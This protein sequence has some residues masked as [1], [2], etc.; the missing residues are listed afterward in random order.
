MGSMS[1]SRR[2]FLRTGA[3]FAAAPLAARAKEPRRPNILFIIAD[4]MGY[5][6]L[7]CYGGE[8]DTPH[9]DRLA[10]R[11][12]RF[13]QF[14]NYGK[15]EPTRTALMTGH[16]NTPEI[17]CYG[18]RAESF[19]PALLR[20]QGYRTLMAGKWHVSRNPTDRGF[21]RFFGIE[22]GACNYY[23]GSGR[24]KL[25][26]TKFPVPAE[27]FY[28]TDAFT[29]YAIRFLDEAQHETPE[30]PFFMYLAYNA[31]HDPLQVPEEDIGKYR[32][33]YRAGWEY[34]KQRRFERIKQMGLIPEDAAMTAWPEN[35][36]HWDELTDG[37]KD[38]EDC[39][40]ATYAAMI[41]RMD[42]QIGRVL[43]WLEKNRKLEN[44]LIVFISD[45]GANPFDRGSRR[46]VEAGILPGGPDSHWSL[47][48]AWAHVSNTPFR[49]YKRN[50]HEGGIC[51]PMILHWPEAGYEAGSL[52]RMPVHVLD[53][54][55]TFHALAGGTAR[56][57]GIEGQDISAA[58][59][60]GKQS[61]PDYR[62]MAYMVDHRYVRRGDW[63]LVSVDGEPWELH[64]LGRD[65]TE[66]V[67]VVDEHPEIARAFDRAFN[68]W[69]ESFRKEPFEKGKGTS[70]PLRMGDRGTGAQYVPVEMP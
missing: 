11:G 27:G 21:E 20:E 44:T 39:R 50:M 60:A 16:R 31:P 57:P 35:L 8:V 54:L 13:T 7:G 53:F 5:S 66:T 56:P 22:E 41:D 32:G 62:T 19:L 23:T 29:D 61:R 55:P 3:A 2:D 30:Q 18:E 1:F 51:G 25:G 33:V 67:N 48:T 40:M 64:H 28:T 59:R 45:N 58:L 14:Y 52:A 43:R 42:R 70:A 38:M 63:K 34:F 46:M 36:P 15:C 47:G 24:I 10:N 68:E 26:K 37:Q 12:V 69:Y 6:D 49:M 9:L 4:D 65:R 17:G